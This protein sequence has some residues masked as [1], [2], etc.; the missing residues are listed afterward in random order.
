MVA[1]LRAAEGAR[2][3]LQVRNTVAEEM[4]LKRANEHRKE[5]KRAAKSAR[6]EATRAANGLLLAARRQLAQAETE[7]R[8]VLLECDAAR[9][10]R[11]EACGERDEA[12]GE[13]D[14]ACGERDAACGER[15]AAL[16]HVGELEVQV[17]SVAAAYA[18]YQRECEEAM[19]YGE[20]PAGRPTGV[21]YQQHFEDLCAAVG[22]KDGRRSVPPRALNGDDSFGDGTARQFNSRSVQHMRAVLEGRGED[23][24][25]I[26]NITAAIQ[27]AGYLDAL[28]EQP[29]IRRRLA[30]EA[31]KSVQAHWSA[32]LAVHVW[33]RLALSREDF[34]TLRHLLSFVYDADSDKYVPLK[35]WQNPDEPNDFV[36]SARLP[37]RQAREK[38]YNALAADCEILV[39]SKGNCE[40]CAIRAASQL[41]SNYRQALRQ[42]YT[43]E[44]PALTVLVLDGT[45][46]ALGRGV[47]HCELGSADFVGDCK[48][49]R[50]TLQPLG[51]CE[52]DDHAVSQRDNLPFVFKT[53]NALNSKRCID[54]DD[55]S[56]IPARLIASADMQ[57]VKSTCGMSLCSHSVWC[58]C[59]KGGAQHSYPEKLVELPPEE[60]AT[61]KGESREYVAAVAAAY[62]EMCGMCDEIGC[63]FKTFDEMCILAHYD[64]G[65]ARGGNFRGKWTCPCCLYSPKERKW[66]ADLA[67][68]NELSEDDQA[69]R[70]SIHNETKGNDFGYRKHYH[71]TLYMPP[72]LWLDMSEFG[73]DGLHLIFLNMFKHLFRYTIHDGLPRK[74]PAAT[75]AALTHSRTHARTHAR[76]HS[77]VCLWCPQRA[78]F[79]WCATTCGA[80]ASTRMTR[81]VTTRTP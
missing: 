41:Y 77:L 59:Q 44:R 1:A 8:N 24:S 45:G 48:Q 76:T 40:R 66:R 28:L 16:A 35:L 57:G 23:A 34:E 38:E 50:A 42:E 47:C 7:L 73:V 80:R 15:G 37:S 11:D 30:L 68:Y 51:A 12:C 71:Q 22:L 61:E 56:V 75:V 46:G 31:Q 53:A 29:D 25:G 27:K 81:R 62:D 33:D 72:A 4:R 6:Q 74:C 70:R 64:P 69:A 10:E 18:Q 2:A 9:K 58:K 60:K 54:R 63:E 67:T 39:G 78:K 65:V 21:N 3:E 14:A 49:S 32:R 36:V 55:G 26:A 5:L 20:L 17:Q 43:A 19:E 52:G 13:R 79:G